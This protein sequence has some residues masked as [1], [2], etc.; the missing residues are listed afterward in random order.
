MSPSCEGRKRE[1]PCKKGQRV[2]LEKASIAKRLR[3]AS[4][5]PF[6]ARRLLIFREQFR[7]GDLVIHRMSG[8]IQGKLVLKPPDKDGYCHANDDKSELAR[9][10]NCVRDNH[11]A[12]SFKR[13]GLRFAD[14]IYS[15]HL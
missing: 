4:E 11:K 7:F 8:K 6:Y 5:D 10:P 3:A 13:E 14:L 2:E 15:S 1:D 9:G 12:W